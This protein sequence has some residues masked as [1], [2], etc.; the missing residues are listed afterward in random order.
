MHN[1]REH[2]AVLQGL[3]DGRQE[4]A[5]DATI[6]DVDFSAGPIKLVNGGSDLGA[7]EAAPVRAASVPRK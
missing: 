7:T 2:L 1:G 6:T 4:T 5:G 3:Q